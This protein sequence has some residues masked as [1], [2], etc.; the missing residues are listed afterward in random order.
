MF[1]LGS[2]KTDSH[3]EA[4]EEINAF[5]YTSLNEF[6]VIID[7]YSSQNSTEMLLSTT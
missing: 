7:T 5:L 1:L 6:G 2:V 4:T 3:S